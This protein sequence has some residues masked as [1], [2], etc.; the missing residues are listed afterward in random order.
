M[1]LP[2]GQFTRFPE[3]LVKD[4]AAEARAARMRMLA[5]AGA[6]IAALWWFTRR[7]PRRRRR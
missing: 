3:A 7:R 1:Y 5:L 4:P 6:G 2:V